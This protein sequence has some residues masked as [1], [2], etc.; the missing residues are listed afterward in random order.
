M[1]DSIHIVYFSGTGGTAFAA[2][3]LAASI[4]G[5]KVRASEIFRDK[6][7]KVEQGE[8]LVLMYPVYAADA[9]AP[10]LRWI[11][12]IKKQE[13]LK[14]VVISV[15]G[16]GEISPNTA[17]RVKSIRRLEK[18]GFIVM[19]E[20]MLCMPS[21]FIAPTDYDLAASLINI[22]PQ[23]C[24]KIADEIAVE[25]TN[26]KKPLII[27]RIMLIFFALEK[28]GAKFFGRLLKA[29]ESCNGCGLC[30]AKCTRANIK[31]DKG[32]PKFGWKCVICMRCLYSCP[33]D[34][35]Y[36][37]FPI[38]KKAVLEKGFDLDSIVKEAKKAS[39]ENGAIEDKGY[40]FKGAVEYIRQD[41]V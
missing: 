16:G 7:P 29:D 19:G 33:K 31:M 38:L 15:S 27:D 5:A 36:A 26:R 35:I 37:R 30:A 13:G 14:A 18:K 20:Y 3:S 4:T 41:S 25:K 21:N 6:N 39:Q 24:K 9:P 22:L 10:V 12:S 32:R 23:K 11:D 28:F 2:K 34:S 1:A 8:M 40:L 17:C